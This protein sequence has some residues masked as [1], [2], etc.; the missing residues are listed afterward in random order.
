ML[1]KLFQ[2][3]PKLPLSA[4]IFY[5]CML[6]LWK[7]GFIPSPSNIL[8][9]LEELYTSYG[10]IGLSLASFLEGIVYLGLYFPGSF[11]IALAV[12]LSNGSFVSL[13]LI[14]LVVAFTLTITSIINYFLG[15]KLNGLSLSTESLLKEKKVLS[16]GLF[17][18]ML[19]PNMLAFYFFNSGIKRKNFMKIIFVPLI[20]IPYGLAMGYFLYLLKTPLKNAI[21][22]PYVMVVVILIW[23]LSAFL[24]ANKNGKP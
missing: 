23:I 19:H 5:T 15:A 22:N 3:I 2:K 20:M 11:I 7:V 10:V 1:K 17:F 6:I 9:I 4:L 8:I 24:I 13:L 21:D 12:I 18:S 16:K 14:S